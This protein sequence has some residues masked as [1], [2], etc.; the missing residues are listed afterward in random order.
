MGVVVESAMSD[1]DFKKIASII[2]KN[3][4][5]KMPDVKKTMLQA[6][7]SQRLRALNIPT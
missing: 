5:I 3:V 7:I 6:R 4:G 2:E 1:S